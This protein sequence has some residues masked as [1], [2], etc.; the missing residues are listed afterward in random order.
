MNSHYEKTIN[1]LLNEKVVLNVQDTTELN[2]TTHKSKKEMGRIGNS[3]CT[4]LMVHTTLSLTGEGVPVGILEQKIWTRSKELVSERS[5]KNIEDKESY[6]WIESLISIDNKFFNEEQVIVTI[7]DR[8]SDIYDL[9]LVDRKRNSHLLVRAAQD[10]LINHEDKKLFKGLD[11]LEVKGNLEVDIS[12][13]K[14]VSSSK[15]KLNI[16]YDKFE[17][18]EPKNHKKNIHSVSLNV[19]LVEEEK[20]GESKEPIRWVLL[21]TLDINSLEDAIKYV[22]WYSYRWLIE[23]YHY[24]L[25]S[26]C[27]IEELQLDSSDKIQKVLAMYSVV[28]CKLLNMTYIVRK[29]PELSCEAF[30]SKK[31]WNLIYILVNKTPNLPKEIPKLKEVIVWIARLGGFLARKGDGFPGVKVL[32]RG[33]IKFKTIL[34]ATEILESFNN[35]TYG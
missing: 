14:G 22:R 27:H 29:E 10:R 33:F 17:I 15:A 2:F 35:Y 30:F 8:E 5:K 25:K 4:G 26:G 32:W 13:K 19:I 6:R 21:T 1:S 9:F 28:S 16:K 11:N 23:R 12:R 7:G 24:V 20:S 31:E 3:N 18:K 34:E